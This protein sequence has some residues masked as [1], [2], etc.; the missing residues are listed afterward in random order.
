MNNI[1]QRL[2][3]AALLGLVVA[4]CAKAPLASIS[5]T[6]RASLE[7]SLMRDIRVLASDEYGG[8]KPGTAG[9]RLTTDY[10]IS[11]L[12]AA[13]FE[14]GTNDPGNAWRAPVELVSV[15]PQSGSVTFEIEGKSLELEPDEAVVF[16]NRARDF[17]E[18]AD[19]V[20]VGYE[21]EDIT[22]EMVAGKVVIML[23]EPGKSP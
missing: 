14:S 17:A 19:V 23:G 18:G 4:G 16:T 9:E 5:A 3:C 8:R 2:I 7:T 1:I 22:D 20:F 10:I 13:G 12:Q 6:E 21:A 15:R 11:N